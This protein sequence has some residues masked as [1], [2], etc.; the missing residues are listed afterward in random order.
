MAVPEPVP[1]LPLGGTSEDPR[2]VAVN[3]VGEQDGIG[4][5]VGPGVGVGVGGGVGAGLGVP[6]PG[7]GVGVAPV[8]TLKAKTLLSA[9]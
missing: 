7:V 5:G 6:C 8:G 9:A 1:A 2:S 3:E 4:V